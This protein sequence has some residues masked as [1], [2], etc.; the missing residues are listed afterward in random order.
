MACLEWQ[1]GLRPVDLIVYSAF[2]FLSHGL[3]TSA[4]FSQR[5]GFQFRVV[6]RRLP[7]TCGT[8]EKIMS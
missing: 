4:K 2:S 6:H 7:T 8:T 1:R 3:L 5:V